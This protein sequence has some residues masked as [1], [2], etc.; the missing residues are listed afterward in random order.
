MAKQLPAGFD[1]ARVL[2]VLRKAMEFGQ[3]TRTADQATFYKMTTTSDPGP[4]DSD[5]VPFDPTVDRTRKATPVLVACAVEYLDRADQTETFGTIQSGLVK[6]TLLDDDYQKVKGFAYVAIGGIKY[7][8][9]K[10]EPPD[11]LG[12]LDVWTVHVVAED[13]S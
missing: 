2:A 9:R 13:E 11:A 3:P 4:V 6:I 12:S 7:A 8:Y 1:R 10:T 5:G